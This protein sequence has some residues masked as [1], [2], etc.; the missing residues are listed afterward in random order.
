[1]ELRDKIAGALYGMALGD[2][3]GVAAQNCG[4]EKEQ[5]NSLVEKSQNSLTDQKR[6]MLHL[7][8]IKLSSRMILDR[9]WFFWIH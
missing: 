7:I 5:E 3:M 8:I 1:M 4:A 6:M 2:A 9:Q